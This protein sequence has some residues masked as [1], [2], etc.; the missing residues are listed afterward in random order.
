MEVA[1]TEAPVTI[2]SSNLSTNKRNREVKAQATNHQIP[3]KDGDLPAR[4]G[5]TGPR[6]VVGKKRSS[7]NAVKF[8]IFSKATLIKG[9]C[10]SDYR[11][12]LEGFW[13]SWQPVGKD[14]ELLVEKLASISWRYRRCLVAEG[15]EI[16]KA[17]EFLE[18]DCQWNEEVE[19]EEI[20][21]RLQA[22]ST[23]DLGLE[24]VG[25]IWKIHNSIIVKYCIKVLALVQLGIM[26]DM[27]DEKRD[28]SLLKKIYG[29]PDRPHFRRT[30][31]DEYLGY[32]RKPD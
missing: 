27:P 28:G 8:G 18:F 30:L 3:Q 17:S 7:R 1:S 21:L 32:H 5:P 22:G 6:T 16:R 9:E 4:R 11:L 19:A 25:L 31:Q 14:E 10:Q 29:D 15:A 23:F 12:L 13:K 2:A 26:I 24:P 20:N